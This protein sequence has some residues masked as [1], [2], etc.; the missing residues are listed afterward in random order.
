MMRLNGPTK[1]FFDDPSHDRLLAMVLSLA[2]EVAALREE[3]HGVRSLMT[4]K[5]LITP[6]E[7]AGYTPSPAAQAERDRM[8][9]TMVSNLLFPLQQECQS[10]TD[11]IRPEPSRA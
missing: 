2:A 6:E 9:E 7:I 3:L 8:R 5:G 11:L 4:D 10:L 1:F